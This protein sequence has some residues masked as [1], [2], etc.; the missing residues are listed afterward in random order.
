MAKAPRQI[1]GPEL[2]ELREHLSELLD[3][4]LIRTSR[5]FYGT[6]ILF[7]TNKDTLELRLCLDYSVLNK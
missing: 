6:P 1:L 2:E 7:Q 5:S 3:V 4:D